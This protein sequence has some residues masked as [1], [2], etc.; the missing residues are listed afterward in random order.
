[1][2]SSQHL[3]EATLNPYLALTISA[4][5]P[6]SSIKHI[7]KLLRKDLSNDQIEQ[8]KHL[9]EKKIYAIMEVTQCLRWSKISNDY[10]DDPDNENQ[11]NIIDAWIKNEKKQL[12][13]A[14][15]QDEEEK[16]PKKKQKNIDPASFDPYAY[17]IGKVIILDQPIDY[18]GNERI[19]SIDP[20]MYRLIA[21][22]KNVKKHGLHNICR[23]MLITAV[24][25]YMYAQIVNNTKDWQLTRQKYDALDPKIMV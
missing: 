4:A 23:R 20:K 1:M 25:R 13:Q 3:E 16:V 18:K 11:V 9:E 22:D 24:D 7:K 2:E 8:C 10:R 6:V 15:D 14:I 19:T 12:Q 5:N 17:N 21:N